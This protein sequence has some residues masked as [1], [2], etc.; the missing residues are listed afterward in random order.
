MFYEFGATNEQKKEA[1]ADT[2]AKVTS[3]STRP[4]LASVGTLGDVLAR[5]KDK[6]VVDVKKVEKE[7]AGE[8]GKAAQTFSVAKDGVGV[9]DLD[10]ASAEDE[11]NN[12]GDSMFLP[13]TRVT[14]TGQEEEES[15][16][17]GKIHAVKGY[18]N[19][20]DR[21]FCGNTVKPRCPATACREYPLTFY[22]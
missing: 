9:Y 3:T 8:G 21:G 16:F 10:I 6:N 5:V 7:E 20:T 17:K 2:R 4:A 14:S 18:V 12:K 1:E 22:A 11:Q 15:P 13:A 19:Y